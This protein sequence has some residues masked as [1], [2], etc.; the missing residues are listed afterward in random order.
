MKK[1]NALHSVPLLTI[2]QENIVISDEAM[3]VRI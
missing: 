1:R 2:D 3:I